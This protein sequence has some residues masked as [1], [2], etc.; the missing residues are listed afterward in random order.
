MHGTT[1]GTNAIIERKGARTALLTTRGFRDAL[2]TG[3]E[4]RYDLHDLF[5]EFPEPL[6]PRSRRIGIAE[7]VRFDGSVLTPLA[8]AEVRDALRA[9]R[10]GGHRGGRRVLPARLCQPGQRGGR[11]RAPSRPS[12]RISSCRCPR[13]FCRRSASTAAS[14]PRWPTPTSS[15]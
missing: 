8:E 14:P 2:E 4:L 9:L 3:T 10:V 7:R 1:L 15:R 11:G 13:A 12:G 6:V 5:I